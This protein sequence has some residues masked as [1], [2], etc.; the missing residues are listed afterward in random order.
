MILSF[1]VVQGRCD[2]VR[3]VA[4][5]TEICAN[6]TPD[7]ASGERRPIVARRSPRS[8]TLAWVSCFTVISYSFATRWAVC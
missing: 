4:K 1:S 5:K 3:T 8:P 2:H 6:P 7:R